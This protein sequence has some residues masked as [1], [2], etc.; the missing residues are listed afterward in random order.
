MLLQLIGRLK[1]ISGSFGVIHPNVK[2]RDLNEK[3]VSMKWKQS[4]KEKKLISNLLKQ[5][6]KE[7]GHCKVNK[8]FGHLNE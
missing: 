5:L 7:K 4:C 1:Q 8:F 6:K 2:L 3:Q